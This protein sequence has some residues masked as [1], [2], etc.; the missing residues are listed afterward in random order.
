M[1]VQSKAAYKD[2][3]TWENLY[4]GYRRAA[5]GKRGRAPAAMFE[6]NLEN[7]LVRLQDELA[8]ESYRPGPYVNFL[9]HEP[10]RRLISAAP[11]RDRVVHHSK[12]PGHSS[13]GGYKK[14][15]DGACYEI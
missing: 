9:I 15:R 11:F 7:N 1:I 10:K 6:F 8:A 2:I 14:M 4:R 3:H 5:K 13:A 12:A